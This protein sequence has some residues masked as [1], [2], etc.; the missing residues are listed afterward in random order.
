MQVN[1]RF[2]G[3]SKEVLVMQVFPTLV[4][5]VFVAFSDCVVLS[6]FKIVECDAAKQDSVCFLTPFS[7]FLNISTVCA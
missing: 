7:P 3:V 4:C 1:C 2:K 5:L 6:E